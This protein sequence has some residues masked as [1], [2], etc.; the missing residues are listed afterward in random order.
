[1]PMEY[2]FACQNCNAIFFRRKGAVTQ[3]IH[4]GYQIK[5]CSNACRRKHKTE[6]KMSR[7]EICSRYRAKNKRKID[8]LT[9]SEA[10]YLSRKYFGGLRDEVLK[11][12]NNACTIC[13]MSNRIIVHH[14]DHNKTNNILSNLT[15]LCRS[16]HINE[17]RSDLIISKSVI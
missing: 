3:S 14:K 9:Q 15:T 10:D 6:N 12:D 8:R 16:C 7:K 13:G 5:Y 11:R 4:G 2:Q 17:H 1:M